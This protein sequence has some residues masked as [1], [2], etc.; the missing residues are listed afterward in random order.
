MTVLCRYLD[1]SFLNDERIFQHCMNA[2]PWESR[3]ERIAAFRHPGDR[4]LS[5]GAGLLLERMLKEAGV[6]DLTLKTEASGKPVLV[7][8]ELQ[9]SI[10]HSGTMAVCTVSAEP[11]GVDAERIRPIRRN[12]IMRFFHPQE[13]TLIRQS[14]QPDLE[15]LRIW[16]RKESYGK[17]IGSGIGYALKQFCFSDPQM[18]AS[19]HFQ[20]CLAE[21]YLITVCTEREAHV[22]FVKTECSEEWCASAAE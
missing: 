13:A 9:F 17:R 14:E 5:L 6:K 4:N 22:Q 20:E 3:R 8:G 12:E 7:S 10:S 15:L 1:V 16:T 18:D 2:L 21:D 11:I 19:V